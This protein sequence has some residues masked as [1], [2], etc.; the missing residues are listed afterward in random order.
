M[1]L[2]PVWLVP[3]WKGE[4]GTQ[5]HTEERRCED[6]VRRWQGD[7]SDVSGSEGM[8]RIASIHQKLQELFYI[9]SSKFSTFTFVVCHVWMWESDHKESWTPKNWCFWTVVLEKTLESPLDCKEI[10]PVNPKG[11]NNIHL[12]DWCWS[13]SSSTLATWWEE[14][15]HWKRPWC[16]ERLKPGGVD[17]MVGW[18][19]QLN[20]HEFEQALGDGEGQGSLVCCSA[21]G[22]KKLDTTEWL[23]NNK[24]LWISIFVGRG[25]L[26]N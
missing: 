19:H 8:L 13:R 24:G 7:L 20:G 23:N 2:Q 10:K 21:W 17:E 22:R 12:K 3:Y 6:T 11:N 26:E 9:Y 18:H 5:T 25:W 1:G 15:T 4:T 14:P 16:W